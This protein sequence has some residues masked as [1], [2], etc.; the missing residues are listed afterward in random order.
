MRSH[1]VEGTVRHRRSRPFV[2]ALQ[3]DVFYLAL[4][5]AELDRI[6]SRFRLLGRNRWRPLTFRDDDHW[7]PPA[8]DLRASV[9]AHLRSE[10]F[11]DADAWQI[12]LVAYPRVLGHVF[13]P[14][15]FY[16]CRDAAGA[17]RVVVVEVHN[18]HHERRLYTLRPVETRAAHVASMDKDHYVSPFISMDA[19]Y[20]VRVQD[21]ADRLRIVIDETEAGEPLL[22]ASVDLARRP[23]TDG[24]LLRALVRFPLVT[25]KTIAMIHWHALHLWRRGARFHSHGAAQ[26]ANPGA[27]ARRSTAG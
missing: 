9:L 10:G 4:D 27:P 14:A 7:L 25:L 16:L 24:A 5:L 17:L 8:T 20:T 13:N 1:L 21:R 26:A 12:T 18:T 3:H 15:S 2:Y 11:T 19:R 6:G 22:Q 23:L